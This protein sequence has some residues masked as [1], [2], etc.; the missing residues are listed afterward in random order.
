MTPEEEAAFRE[1]AR[2]ALKVS[3]VIGTVLCEELPDFTVLQ[4]GQ[5][6]LIT[7]P[8]TWAEQPDMHAR[9]SGILSE[10]SK[11]LAGQLLN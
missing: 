3:P 10:E 1:A 8:A 2:H 7:I 6:V 11:A 9:I 5:G 4:C